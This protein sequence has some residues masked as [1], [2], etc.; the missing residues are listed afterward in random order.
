MG[1]GVGIAHG[2]I[3]INCMHKRRTDGGNVAMKPA[4]VEYQCECGETPIDGQD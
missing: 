2:R 1:T 3:I 4:A